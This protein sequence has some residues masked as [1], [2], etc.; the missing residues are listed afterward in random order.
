MKRGSSNNKA[1]MK[2]PFGM[3]FSIILIVIFISFA[4]YA[5]SKFLSMG[6]AVTIGKFVDNFQSDINKIWK[7]SQA[8]QSFKYDV[9]S[10]IE[11]VCLIDYSSSVKG[12]PD[13]YEELKEIYYELRQGYNE[14]ENLFFYPMSSSEGIDSLEIKNINLENITK[15]ENPFCFN[16]K[17]G[18]IELVLKK[19]YDEILVRIER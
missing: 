10:K 12:K 6:N 3:I 11:K 14:N 18:E 17:K 2:L 15:E 1:Q 5:I 19:R 7:S 8:S 13:I 16:S 9:P 4:F